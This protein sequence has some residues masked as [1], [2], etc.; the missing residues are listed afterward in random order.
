MGLAIGG[1]PF[2][3]SKED[4]LTTKLSHLVDL[5]QQ[6]GVNWSRKNS[7]WPMPFA[8]AAARS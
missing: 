6:H 7:L 8:T 4:F 3:T 2:Q 1:S 5:I